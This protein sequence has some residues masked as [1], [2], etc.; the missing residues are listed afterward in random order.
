MVRYQGPRIRQRLLA[1][2][3]VERSQTY[4]FCGPGSLPLTDYQA[5]PRMTGI[6]G[7]ERAFVGRP[8][9]AIRTGAT[10]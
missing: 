2:S 8:S 7:G 6:T 4:E 10:N 5:T 3:D 9:T 1:Q